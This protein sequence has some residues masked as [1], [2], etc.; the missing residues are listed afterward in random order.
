M[1]KTLV[2][3]AGLA[4]L[5]TS[6]FAS[7]ARM[8][9]LGQGSTFGSYYMQDTRNI[10]RM[11]HSM[12]ANS[13]FVITEWGDQDA[14]NGEN[15]EG[16]FFN[17]AASMNYG[18]YL[19]ANALGNVQQD[20]NN[21]NP[22]RFDLFV[23]GNGNMNW[24]ARLGYETITNKTAALDESASGLDFTVSAELSGANV[25]LTYVAA[26]DAT[27][28]GSRDQNADMRLG[29]TYGMNDYTLFAE[30]TSEGNQAAITG[31]EEDETSTTLTIGA[32]RTM[33]MSDSAT[34]FYDAKIV[35]TS[36]LSAGAY[37]KDATSLSLPVTFGV[38]AKANSW[39]TLRASISQPV[40]S[41][42][43]VK[44]GND[45]EESSSRSTTL[46]VGASLTYG[47]LQLDGTVSN[48]DQGTLGASNDV[49]SN[50][51]MTYVF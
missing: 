3:A 46:G 22:N 33:S 51:S 2:V 21:N 24:G 36:N 7:K 4:V 9:A 31:T 40:Y 32:G 38:E 6:A 48:A 13:N 35:S 41:N 50:V 5:S 10:W 28:D 20:T 16:G 43:E 26:A 17:S 27:V 12:N 15:A 42:Q 23:A 29:A 1:K 34:V 44:N 8:Q 11:P 39:L 45:T 30:Y 25:W 37:S 14:T 19:N 49:I 47:S 18:I